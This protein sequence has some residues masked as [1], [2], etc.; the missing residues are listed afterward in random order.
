M[1]NNFGCP[2]QATANV[3]AGKWKVLVVWHLSFGSRRFAEIRDFLPGASE[4]VLTAQLRELQHDGIIERIVTP[5]VPPRVDYELT[6]RGKELI[7][8]ME[9]MCAWSMKHL[10]ITPKWPRPAASD[11][12]SEIASRPVSTTG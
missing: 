7:T 11:A 5:T 1:K 4:K 10:G 3:M 6:D 12:P 8:V 2:V 9:T